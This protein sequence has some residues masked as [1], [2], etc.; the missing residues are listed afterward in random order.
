M[1]AAIASA[2]EQGL[3]IS[4]R[5]GAHNPA[6]TAVGDGGLMV[7][8]S[9]LREVTVDPEARRVRVGGGALLSDMDSATQA[10]GLAVPAGLIGHTRVGGLTLGGGMGWLTRRFGLSIDSLVSAEVVIADGRVLRAAE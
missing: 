6:G 1:V 5:G 8:L 7:D 9:E 3:E 2:R 4:V 10:H